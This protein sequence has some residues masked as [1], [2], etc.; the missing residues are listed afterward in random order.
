MPQVA[1]PSGS[2]GAPYGVHRAVDDIDPPL[3]PHPMLERSDFEH[4]QRARRRFSWSLTAAMLLAYFGFIL[5]LAFRPD[6]LA[7]PLVTGQPMSV[8]IPVGFGMFAFTFALVAVYVYR[9][10]TVYD[11]MIAEVR[12]GAQS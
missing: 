7:L 2:L 10:N 5:T 3:T 12:A 6:L 8:G 11:R 1:P 4:L 9:T